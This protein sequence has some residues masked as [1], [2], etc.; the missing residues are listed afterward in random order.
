MIFNRH[1]ELEGRYALMSPSKPFWIGESDDAFLKRLVSGYAS[2]IGN[3]LHEE[4]RKYITHRFKARKSDKQNLIMALLEGGIPRAVINT[5]DMDRQTANFMNYVNDSV[6]FMMEP[7]VTLK[8]SDY[9]FGHTDAIFYS[10]TDRVLRINDMKTGTSPVHMEQLLGYAGQFCLEYAVNPKSLKLCELRIYQ[11][12]DIIFDN[13]TSDMLMTLINEIR[14][15][16]E[17]A[18]QFLSV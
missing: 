2:Q 17:L 5:L 10:D 11:N 1:L 16:D 14:H 15:K 3:I 7:E 13:P 4:A 18:R 9:C 8:Y 6:S 12:G